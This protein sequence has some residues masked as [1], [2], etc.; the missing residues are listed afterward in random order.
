MGLKRCCACHIE[1]PLECFYKCKSHRDGH[2]ALCKVCDNLRSREYRQTH[3]KAIAVRRR[4]YREKN[5]EEITKRK[6]EY[7]ERNKEQIHKKNKVYRQTH[8]E[9]I[10]KRMHRYL[11][12]Y[13]KQNKER[14]HKY[15]H[16]YYKANK[17]RIT[18]KHRKYRL[19]E[20]GKLAYRRMYHNRLARA[21]SVKANLTLD[22]WDKILIIQNNRCNIC[23]KKFTEKRIPT[24]DHIIPVSLGGDLTFENIQALCLSC[25]STKQAKLDLQFIQT[26]AYER[27]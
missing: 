14:I 1:K 5:K 24:M 10:S 27:K 8:K 18:E 21:K 11:H 15:Q 20:R 4:N 22:Q 3:K 23:H 26:W 19:T 25:N 17:E 2:A 16:N 12:E 13:H 9:E 6:H 7:Y